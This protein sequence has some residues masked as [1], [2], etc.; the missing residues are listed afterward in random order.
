M[1][2]FIGIGT[3]SAPMRRVCA[4]LIVGAMALA[5]GGCAHNVADTPN[6]QWQVNTVDA[7][8]PGEPAP[9]ASAAASSSLNCGH[10]TPD[11]CYVYR[12]GRDPNTGLALTQL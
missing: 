1:F 6:L 3:N 7:S 11:G 12:G 2:A 10:D 9:G 8:D 5:G 4:L